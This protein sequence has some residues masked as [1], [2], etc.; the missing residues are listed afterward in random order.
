MKKPF[1]TFEDREIL[2]K[3]PDSFTAW[4]LRNEISSKKFQRSF[5]KTRIGKLILKVLSQ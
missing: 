1:V 2:R 5:I 4:R 3:L